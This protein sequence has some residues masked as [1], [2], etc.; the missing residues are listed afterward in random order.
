MM[1]CVL[2][3]QIKFVITNSVIL[4]ASQIELSSVA[5]KYHFV[6]LADIFRYYNLCNKIFNLHLEINKWMHWKK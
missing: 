5:G 2:C 6:L 3:S 1:I 4:T